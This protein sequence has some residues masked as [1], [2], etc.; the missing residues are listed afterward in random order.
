MYKAGMPSSLLPVGYKIIGQ[1]IRGSLISCY[2]HPWDRASP[3]REGLPAAVVGCDGGLVSN[4]EPQ[5]GWALPRPKAGYRL[6]PEVASDAK[7]GRSSM[8]LGDFHWP[9]SISG[10][11][12]LVTGGAIPAPP[13]AAGDCYDASGSSRTLRYH[14]GHEHATQTFNDVI[15]CLLPPIH[16]PCSRRGAVHTAGSTRRSTTQPSLTTL[17]SDTAQGRLLFTAEPQSQT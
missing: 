14:T 8:G 13:D 17:P 3:A 1:K 10:T 5:Q 12:R 15:Y 7:Q 2:I 9:E 16:G 11:T 6:H 4:N